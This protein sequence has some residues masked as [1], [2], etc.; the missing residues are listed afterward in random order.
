MVMSM[1]ER[2]TLN[3]LK[4]LHARHITTDDTQDRSITRYILLYLATEQARF[5]NLTI[6]TTTLPIRHRIRL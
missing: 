4:T 1:L 5:L 2:Q 6:R 3:K